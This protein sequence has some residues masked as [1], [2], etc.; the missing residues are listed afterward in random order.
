[1]TPKEIIE[2]MQEMDEEILL[3]DGFEDALVGYVEIFNKTI[4]LYDREK[5]ITVLMER[6]KMAREEAE[7][8]FDYNVTGGY[9]GEKTPGFATI[10]K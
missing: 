9:H 2:Y 10:L 6:D 8:F 5:C 7:E 1:M 4:A 3:A